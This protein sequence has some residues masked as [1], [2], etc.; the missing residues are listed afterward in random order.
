MQPED[1]TDQ[2]VAGLN[3]DQLLPRVHNVDQMLREVEFLGVYT[4]SELSRLKQFV[5]DSKKPL[6]PGC[7]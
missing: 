7:C 3:D 4:S 6:Y 5:E 2:E 1:M